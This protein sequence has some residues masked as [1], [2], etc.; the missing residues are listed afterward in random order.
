MTTSSDPTVRDYRPDGGFDLRGLVMLTCALILAGGVLGFVAHFISQ[1]FYL[2]VMF[3]LAIGLG[4]GV[5]GAQVARIARVRNPWIGG[6]AGLAA[7]IFAM[8]MMHY[9]DYR[10]FHA[11]QAAVIAEDPEYVAMI[12]STPGEIPFED[13]SA[14]AESTTFAVPKPIGPSVKE[15]EFREFV[16]AMRVQSFAGYIDHEARRGVELKSSHGGSGRSGSNLGYV[17]SYIYWIAETLIVAAV[18]FIAI[19]DQTRKPYCRACD[20]WRVE[21]PVGTFAGNGALA[22]AGVR[23]GDL[24]KLAAAGPSSEGFGEHVLHVA[25]CATNCAGEAPEADVRLEHVTAG[26]KGQPQKKTLAHATWPAATADR[27][28]ALFAPPAADAAPAAAPAAV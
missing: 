19:R 2:I 23:E 21:R 7:G 6:L 1:W 16:D 14:P 28:L 25:R 10:T 17:G 4:V 20:A 13:D 26:A 27:V 24:A 3:P 15:K 9:F 8:A 5:A 11:Q 12:R 18:A 22:T